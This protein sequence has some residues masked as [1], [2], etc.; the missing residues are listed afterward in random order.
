MIC[1]CVGKLCLQ[2]E[3]LAK[4]CVP[5]LARELEVSPDV[6]VR[7]NVVIV[8]CD[9]CIRFVFFYSWFPWFLESLYVPEI[10]Q[11]PGKC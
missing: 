10:F 4:Q 11:C 8:M 7:N 6:A 9:L 1:Q 5:A 3:N 2:N